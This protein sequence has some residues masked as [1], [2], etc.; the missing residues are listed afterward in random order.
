M[1]SPKKI[2]FNNKSNE[3]FGLICDLCFEGGDNGETS[4]FLSRKA[5]TTETYNGAFRRSYGMKYDEVLAPKLTLMKR[6]FEDFTF[7]EQRAILS[8]LTSKHTASYMDVYMT[9]DDVAADSPTYC[10]LGGITEIETYKLGNNRT[11]GVVFT[12]ES[13]YPYALSKTI[14]ITNADIK[15]GTI[16]NNFIINCKTDDIESFVYPAI[17]VSFEENCDLTITN[18]YL[19]DNKFITETTT[20]NGNTSKEKILIDS[21]NKIITSSNKSRIFGEKFNWVW[22][23]LYYGSNDFTLNVSTSNTSQYPPVDVKYPTVGVSYR[24]PI[25]CGQF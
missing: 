23:R 20:I 10:L 8:W 13:L 11:V 25:K 1:I 14:E 15:N 7:E 5:V 2:T 3:D 21:A 16:L 18:E 9:N 12:F 4:S 17:G 22:P 6:D 24:Y 19:K